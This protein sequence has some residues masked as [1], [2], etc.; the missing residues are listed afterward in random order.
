MTPRTLLRHL[1]YTFAPP[2]ETACN[3][4]RPLQKQQFVGGQPPIALR[5]NPPQKKEVVPDLP[6]SIALLSGGRNLPA[7]DVER[8][9]LQ[10]QRDILIYEGLQ[11]PLDWV[12][13]NARRFKLC[14]ID[15][16]LMDDTEDTVDF[17][18]RLRSASPEMVILLISSEVRGHDL[19]AERMAICD[20]TL[21][22]PIS[23]TSFHNGLT[24]AIENH[25]DY[26]K[27]RMRRDSPALASVH[28]LP[29]ER[30]S[31]AELA[32]QRRVDET[33]A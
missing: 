33:L 8:W 12:V 18:F 20:A 9:C 26:L 22:A 16:D 19:T 14:I 21:H 32:R 5:P 30:S 11:I 7:C 6:T 3:L 1:R 25:R 4:P 15:A 29:Q 23:K 27:R 10:D 24:A 2:D 28:H 31:Q 13:R 17:C